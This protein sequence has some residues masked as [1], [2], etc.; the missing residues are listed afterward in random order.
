MLSSPLPAPV[1]CLPHLDP[2]LTLQPWCSWGKEAGP[3]K[4]ENVGEE[5]R[6]DAGESRES[7]VWSW[8]GMELWLQGG[9]GKEGAVREMLDGQVD[10]EVKHPKF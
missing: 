10:G 8:V 9:G 4:L 2:H 6:G 1:T 3:Q 7:G 5:G